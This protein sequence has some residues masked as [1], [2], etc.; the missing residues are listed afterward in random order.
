MYSKWGV[1]D[2]HQ[3][4][5][6]DFGWPSKRKFILSTLAHGGNSVSLDFKI[7]LSDDKR[8]EFVFLSLLNM[9]VCDLVKLI[10]ALRTPA[11]VKY[12]KSDGQVD[13]H[14]RS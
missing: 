13:L 4:C 11:N 8:V 2:I 10:L 1:E 7:P 3:T 9:G 12:F 14:S 6:W 5:L